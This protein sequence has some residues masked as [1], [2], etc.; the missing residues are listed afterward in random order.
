VCVCVFACG[1][2]AAGFGS[3]DDE[4]GKNT[5][6]S[7]APKAEVVQAAYRAAKGDEPDQGSAPPPPSFLVAVDSQCRISFSSLTGSDSI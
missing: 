6:S 2:A 5:L 1:G 4:D 7:L 3:D